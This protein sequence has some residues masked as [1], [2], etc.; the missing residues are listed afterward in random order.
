LFQSKQVPGHTTKDI[1]TD[2]AR[3]NPGNSLADL[4][5][6][7]EAIRSVSTSKSGEH[8]STPDV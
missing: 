4:L 1:D 5:I 7:G 3:L 8:P 6:P 2:L